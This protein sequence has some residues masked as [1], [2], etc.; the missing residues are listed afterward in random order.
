LI[1]LKASEL[2]RFFD[3]F[4][5]DFPK[6]VAVTKEVAADQDLI[7]VTLAAK[8]HYFRFLAVR[9]SF[10]WSSFSDL[11]VPTTESVLL[12]CGRYSSL[13]IYPSQLPFSNVQLRLGLLRLK[14]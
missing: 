3:V 4:D 9:L 12:S 11:I 10:Y 7:T 5:R 2:I 14:D 13:L 6:V 1:Q 8:M